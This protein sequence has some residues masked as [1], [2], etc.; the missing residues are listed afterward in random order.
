[1]KKLLI[2]LFSLLISFNSYGDSSDKTFCFGTGDA[3][4]LS[5]SIY[6]LNDLTKPFSGTNLCKYEN[7]QIKQ[8]EY[9]KDGKC[10]SGC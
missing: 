5:D 4:I 8:E 2:L 7:G 3:V 1:M 6:L 9:F 10:T